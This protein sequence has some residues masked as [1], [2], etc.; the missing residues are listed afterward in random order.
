MLPDAG[1]LARDAAGCLYLLRPLM[2]DRPLVWHAGAAWSGAGDF[3]QAEYWNTCVS[4]FAASLR[5]PLC[6][7]LR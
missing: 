2:T 1:T 6:V 5:A 4:N 7:T 3:V